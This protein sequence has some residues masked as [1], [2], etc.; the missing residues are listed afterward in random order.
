MTSIIV[1]GAF[2]K[3]GTTTCQTIEQDPSFN[4]IAKLGKQ[5]NLAEAL[6]KH[7]PKLVI[8]FTNAHSVYKNTELLIKQK[9]KCVIGAS[10]LSNEQ[11]QALSNLAKENETGCIIAPNFSLGAILM[12]KFSALAAKYFTEAEI[13]ET[14][15]QQKL[16]SPSG[17]AIKTAHLINEAR[18]SAKNACNSE[19][20]ISGARGAK[21][22]E[23]NIHSL[24]LPGYLA[25]QQVMFGSMGENLTISHNSI[26]RDCFMPGVLLA[27]KKAIEINHLIYGL[28]N[29]LD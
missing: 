27:C 23:T 16:D 7:K 14:H 22:S 10:G 4:L 24:R 8:D 28:E 11:V 29:L 5:D 26:S 15:H 9:T 19:E 6:L 17:T 2:G 21:V 18:R 13:V 1:N 12:M 25:S 3:M 20:L